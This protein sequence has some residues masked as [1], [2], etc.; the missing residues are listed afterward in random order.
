M[1]MGEGRGKMDHKE[2]TYEEDRKDFLKKTI[3]L[4]SSVIGSI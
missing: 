1:L 2:K 3:K 4:L